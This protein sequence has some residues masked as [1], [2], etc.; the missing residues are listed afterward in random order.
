MAEEQEDFSL[1][2]FMNDESGDPNNED[3]VVQGESGS[4]HEGEQELNPTES[5]AIELGWKNKDEWE[6]E[7]DDW[8]SASRFLKF[9]DLTESNKSLRSQIDKI[10]NNFNSRIENLQ[11]FHEQTIQAKLA[12]LKSQRDTAASEADMD[13]YNSANKAIDEIES[14]QIKQPANDKPI[15]PQDVMKAIVDLPVTQKFIEDNQ[16]IKGNGAKGV[17]GQKVLIDWVT[18]NASNPNAIIEDGLKLV[19]DSVAREFG[20]K[21]KPTGS[22]M[23]D[24][25]KNVQSMSKKSALS[26]KQLTSEEAEIWRTMGKSWKSQE[27][28]LQ[29]VADSRKGV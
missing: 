24:K 13:V 21:R 11:Q 9:R 25:G 3:E 4:E 10:E 16:W 5:K 2:E 15:Q 14:K 18:E 1:D 7:P 27:E 12:E 23:A 29:T 20:E 19:S 26:M 8:N 22:A 6:G 28:F 17:Y